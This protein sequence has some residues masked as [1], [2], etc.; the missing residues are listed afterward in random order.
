MGHVS[1]N[2]SSELCIPIVTQDN[3]LGVIQ[4]KRNSESEPFTKADADKL[5]GIFE[6]LDKPIANLSIFLTAKSLNETLLRKN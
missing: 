5:M 4:F 3:V 2:I 6:S 1:E